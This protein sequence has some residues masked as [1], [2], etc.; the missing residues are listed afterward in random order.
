MTNFNAPEKLREYRPLLL[1]LEAIGWL[2]MTEKA[3]VNFLKEKG[4]QKIEDN[5]DYKNWFE[6]NSQFSWESILQW[7]KNLYPEDTT[8]IKWPDR[9]TEF[10]DKYANNDSK[11]NIVGL[12]QAGHAMA[13]GIEKQSYPKKTVEYLGQDITHMWLSTAFG[14]P[15]RNLLHESH[16]LLTEAGWK[17]L[18]DQIN[19]LLTE[20]KQLGENNST[21][22]IDAWWSWRENAVG[23]NGWLRRAFSSTLAET[24]LPNNDVTLFDQSYVAAAL[25]KSAV[26]GAILEG[27]SFPWE[28]SNLI[29]ETRW[30][31][32]T[33][34]IES[35]QYEA[36]AVKIGD[37]NG[38]RLA[39][40]D[41]FKE[42]RRLVEVDLGVG[43][44]LYRDNEVCIFSFP[45]ERSDDEKENDIFYIQDWETFL[46]RTID[47][48]AQEVSLEIPPYCITSKPSRSLIGMTK[49][50]QKAQK[51]MAVPLHRSWKISTE[52]ASPL[53]HVCPVC[54]VRRNNDPTNKEKPCQICKN[55]RHHRQ[56]EWLRGNYGKDTIWISEVADSNDRLALLTFNFDLLPWLSG[57]NV[58]SFRSQAAACWCY[59]NKKVQKQ[60]IATNSPFKTLVDYI[61]RKLEKGNFDEDLVLGSLHDGYQHERQ[62]NDQRTDKE[63][64]K[65]FFNKIVQDRATTEEKPDWD[66]L[67]N[68]QRSRWLVHQLFRKNA[69]PG[70]TYRFW[71]STE[72]FFQSLLDEYRKISEK[73]ENHWRTKR[74]IV[75]ANCNKTLKNKGIYNGHYR[76]A[77]ISLLYRKE[78]NDFLTICNLARILEPRVNKNRI[79][80]KADEHISVQ[81]EEDN[82]ELSL[83]IT[84]VTENGQLVSYAP[85]IPLEVNPARFRIL[86]PL[87]SAQSCIDTAIEKWE[88]EFSRV[89]DRFPLRVGMVAFSRKTPFQAVIEAARTLEDELK[90]TREENWRVADRFDRQGVLSLSL[91]RYDGEAELKTMPMTMPDGR[92]KDVFYPYCRVKD[93]QVRFPLDFQHPEGQVYRHFSDLSPGDG[94][95]V[96]PSKVGLVFLDSTARRFEKMSMR[97]LSSWKYLRELWQLIRRCSPSLSA[98]RGAWSILIDAR[99]RWAETD[100]N[101]SNE[102]QETWLQLVRSV[103]SDK[104]NVDQSSLEELVEASR[105]GN[106]ELC[107]EWNLSV[108]KS[109][110]KEETYE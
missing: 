92:R 95:K 32:L 11:P 71:R 107:L 104:L 103:L 12:F 21:N 8:H 37:L 56:E 110:L 81:E 47:D 52:M 10:I 70:R 62:Y 3:N 42:V 36:R 77:P 84:S 106:L 4:G 100:G 17:E 24:R 39:V 76:N 2:H 45:G 50:I 1:A 85:I 98:L 79:I 94:I 5:S 68:D 67:N 16:E 87:E 20:L 69:S 60:G 14:H 59:K 27:A 99:E 89:W 109:D 46:K 90:Q 54:S 58:D 96:N 80:S 78:N 91:S 18:L 82:K 26:A 28:S 101:L 51:I 33:I 41:F 31:L 57:E 38:F 43:S 53:G 65:S 23:L 64:W 105:T 48:F 9:L 74:L 66:K 35:I 49:E 88:N 13:S 86:V 40:D 93:R 55:R 72:D 30:R 25:F 97:Y 7:T 22:T 29:Q 73:S 108:F 6:N 83:E 75:G 63:I 61:K 19:H 102:G 15:M 44:L 34:G